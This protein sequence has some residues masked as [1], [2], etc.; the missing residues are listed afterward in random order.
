MD[1]RNVITSGV[2]SSER[3]TSWSG[4]C[5]DEETK[6]HLV[7]CEHLAK[8]V[9]MVSLWQ[10]VVTI[11]RWEYAHDVPVSSQLLSPELLLEDAKVTE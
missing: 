8:F 10:S 5:C 3:P 11:R 1:V 9:S 7:T 4:G 6:A 2:I